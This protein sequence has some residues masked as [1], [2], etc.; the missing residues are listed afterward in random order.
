MKKILL[1]ICIFS[2][3]CF[4]QFKRTDAEIA[5]LKGKVKIVEHRGFGNEEYSPD[6]YLISQSST[7]GNCFYYTKV[8]F[9][10]FDRRTL[11]KEINDASNSGWCIFALKNEQIY[12]QIHKIE[13]PDKSKAGDWETFIN[14]EMTYTVL[15]DPKYQYS[16]YSADS[17]IK[18]IEETAKVGQILAWKQTYY[19]DDNLRLVEKNRINYDLSLNSTKYFYKEKEEFPGSVENYINNRLHDKYSFNYEKFDKTGNW[20][21]VKTTNTYNINNWK[22]PAFT[23]ERTITYY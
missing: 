10:S 21:K 11:K 9:Q 1:C 17:K 4:G 13:S 18:L 2:F 19:F 16:G 22:S 14:Y 6:G 12:L 3:S 8:S 15:D 20:L 23:E 7:G 5:G